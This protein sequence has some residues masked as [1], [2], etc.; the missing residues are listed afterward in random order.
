M[1]EFRLKR[2]ENLLR[3]QISSMILSDEIKDPRVST[4]V[5]ITSVQVSKDLSYAKVFISSY[6]NDEMLK[7]SAAALNHAA[8]F[9]QGRVGRRMKLRVTPRLTF[10]PDLSIREG[11]E[12]THR[13]EELNS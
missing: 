10:V 12:L 6:Q 4:F 7:G 11:F 8:G 5:S 9:I 3:D 13:I 1:G 2:I